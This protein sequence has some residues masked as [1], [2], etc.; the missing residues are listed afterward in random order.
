MGD[1]L[2]LYREG[3][4][5][6]PLPFTVEDGKAVGTF[7]PSTG[8]PV[9]AGY[10]Q[11]SLFMVAYPEEGVYSATFTA[12]SL[13]DDELTP[14]TATRTITVRAERGRSGKSDT[15]PATPAVPAEPG[16]RP[17]I[18]AIPALPGRGR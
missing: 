14:A 8:F 7:G 6:L 12:L 2:I 9:P 1:L 13:T 18:P 15:T 16:I 11:T 3:S 17:A 10:D 4:E 5:W